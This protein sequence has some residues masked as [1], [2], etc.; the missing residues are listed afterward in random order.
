MGLGRSTDPF[1]LL[2][3]GKVLK[4]S[5]SV[6]GPRAEIDTMAVAF[7]VEA[8]FETAGCTAQVSS[9][10]TPTESWRF[11]QSLPGGG[12]VSLGVAGKAWV[13][14][15]LP[16]RA[17]DDN[18][19]ALPVVEAL[20]VMR[21]ACREASSFCTPDRRRKGHRFEEAKVIRLDPV[22]D[23]DGVRHPGLLLDGLA[24]IPRGPREK[25][26]RWSDSERNQ[27]ESLRVG[28]KAWGALLYDK[29]RETSGKAPEGRLRFEARLHSPQLISAWARD[30]GGI[31]RS[32]ADVNED[33]VVAI[34][35]GAFHRVGYER[36]VSAMSTVSDAVFSCDDV[37]VRERAILWAYLTAPG[38]SSTLHRDTE[39]KY[40]RI[41]KMLGVTPGAA[42]E[43]AH[44][45]TARLDFD[46]GTEV[47]SAA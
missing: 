15:S 37:S 4:T 46:A 35:L 26:R 36:E 12:F 7:P 9:F 5:A 25:V 17:G 44:K 47:L 45:Y 19:E 41:A 38:F 8:V 31:M 1:P 42:L 43:E 14:A 34:R 28:P 11:R 13:E 20:D 21:E 30:L 23:F 27:A 2:T 6:R 39:R 18:I 40:R 16:K 29:H 24:G 32:V 22:R 10:G 3:E 33:K